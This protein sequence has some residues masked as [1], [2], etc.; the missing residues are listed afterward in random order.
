MDFI[1]AIIAPKDD[2]VRDRPVPAAELLQDMFVVKR[3]AQET[4]MLV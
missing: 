2:N 1:I 3:A 4:V